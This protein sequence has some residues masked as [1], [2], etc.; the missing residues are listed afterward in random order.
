M[1][2]L[3]DT[4]IIVLYSRNNELARAIE[5]DLQLLKDPTSLFLSSVVL[6]EVDS[7]TKQRNF[8]EERRQRLQLLLSK[9]TLLD[10]NIP[11]IIDTYGTLDAY[12]QGK[13]SGYPS[14]FT[15]RNMG[16]N[17]LWIAATAVHY[18]LRLVTTDH[19]FAHLA[20]SFLD[21]LLVEQNNY[22]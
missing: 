17:D 6:G 4:N 22:Y 1:K 19:D 11:P 14:A 9:M 10:I 16:K 20:G 12:S 2:Y 15:A 7:F 3:L 18:G 8:G 5:N 13:L 21:L